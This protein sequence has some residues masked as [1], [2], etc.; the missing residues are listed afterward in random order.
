MKQPFN[1]PSKGVYRQTDPATPIPASCTRDTGPVTRKDLIKRLIHEKE[2]TE[3]MPA[4]PPS[5]RR[6]AYFSKIDLEPTVLLCAAVRDHIC[7]QVDKR[8]PREIYV[9]RELYLLIKADIA[10]QSLEPFTGKYLCATYDRVESTQITIG[11]DYMINESLP[12]NAV[13]CIH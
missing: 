1:L 3:E 2:D 8:P 6:T 12:I 5:P 10:L 7:Q 13:I 11:L 4:M 9:C